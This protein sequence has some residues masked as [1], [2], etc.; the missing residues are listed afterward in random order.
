[1]FPAGFNPA[2]ARGGLRRS[3]KRGGLNRSAN[4]GLGSAHGMFAEGA[5]RLRESGKPADEKTEQPQGA[6]QQDFRSV[7]RSS[8]H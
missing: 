1:M 3:G 7:L 5:R 8:K 2:A 6:Q 4:D